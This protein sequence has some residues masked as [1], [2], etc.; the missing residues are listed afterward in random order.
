ME[1]RDTRLFVIG[2]KAQGYLRFRGY[3]IDQNFNDMTDRPHSTV[4]P[5]RW[6]IW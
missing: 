3:R 1:G 6:P 5:G 2:K 4:M